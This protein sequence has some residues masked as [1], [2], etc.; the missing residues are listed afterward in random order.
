M[1]ACLRSDMDASLLPPANQL[2]RA[3]RAHVTKMDV[4]ARTSRQEDVAYDHDLLGLRRHAL[5]TESRTDDAFVH[6]AAVS[7]RWLLAPASRIHS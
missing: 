1:G 4:T 3:P 6:R 5:E 7:Q 2:H